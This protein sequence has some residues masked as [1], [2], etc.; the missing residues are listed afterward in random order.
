MLGWMVAVLECFNGWVLSWVGLTGDD[1]GSS[2]KIAWDLVRK[3]G[4]IGLV[5]STLPHSLSV[6]ALD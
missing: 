6:H 5:D 2:A 3:N 1:L 4:T